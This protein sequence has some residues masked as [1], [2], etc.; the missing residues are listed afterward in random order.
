MR[1]FSSK[2][3]PLAYFTTKLARLSH[4]I[5][6][7]VN[8]DTI[9]LDSLLRT[10]VEELFPMAYVDANTMYFFFRELFLVVPFPARS[11]QKSVN[12]LAE[13]LYL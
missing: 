13:W 7:H 10:S 12:D 11:P 1:I 5:A 6:F 9:L 2:N 3:C 8:G 4:P